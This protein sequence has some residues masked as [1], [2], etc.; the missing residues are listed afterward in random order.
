MNVDVLI[1][2][3]KTRGMGI[4]DLRTAHNFM[5]IHAVRKDENMD[6][7]PKQRE[8]AGWDDPLWLFERDVVSEHH[9][10]WICDDAI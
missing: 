4:S 1:L 6:R 2:T 10:E 3:T 7:K 8:Y 5:E 9:H